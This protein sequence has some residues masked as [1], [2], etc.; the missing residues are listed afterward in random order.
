MSP[1]RGR[2]APSPTGL[3]HLGHARTFWTA[4]QRAQQANGV[5]VMRNENLDPQRS[6]TEYTT[7]MFEDLRWLGIW[8]QEGPD[9]GG[10]YIPY[11]QSRR[12]EFYLE[13]WRKL[14]QTGFVYPCRCSRKDLARSAQAPHDEDDE[15][16][17]PGT[18][19]PR[20]AA[21]GEIAVP[22]SPARL[23]WRFRVPDGEEIA[24]ADGH[25][26][27]KSYL[28]GL[29]FGDFLIWR[30]DDVPAYQLA[31]VVDDAAMRITEVV[32]GADLLRS[33]ARQLLVYSALGLEPPA[34][35]HCPLMLDATGQRLAKRHD[36]LSLRALREQGRTQEDVV[37]ML[38]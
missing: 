7:A 32:R 4:Y 18:C 5:L 31:V 17:Y 26:G 23:N 25:L 36:A 28:A 24:F 2:L 11:V 34:W 13:A 37:A 1:Y 6:K 12:R 8:W 3:L 14:V 22:E 10:P 15:P 29:D 21:S 9:V 30:R 16:I 33:A 19:R 27:Q 35:Y 20:H 38:R